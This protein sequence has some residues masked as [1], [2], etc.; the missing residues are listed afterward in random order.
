MEWS[1]MGVVVQVTVPAAARCVQSSWAAEHLRGL[2]WGG[3]IP[4]QP[5]KGHS[6][7]PPHK[8]QPPGRLIP[9]LKPEISLK[10]FLLLLSGCQ[11][12]GWP[13]G[14]LGYSSDSQGGCETC[15]TSDDPHLSPGEGGTGV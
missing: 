2:R 13:F 7:Y 10:P 5:L 1:M 15:S 8:R 6:P 11:L 4:V 9:A 3:G 14:A 12:W